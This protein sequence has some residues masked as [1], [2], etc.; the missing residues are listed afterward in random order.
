MRFCDEIVEKKA[1][2]DIEY[3]MDSL[4]WPTP[5]FKIVLSQYMKGN[6]IV[7]YLNYV[8]VRNKLVTKTM[9]LPVV[10]S[11]IS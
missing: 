3:K 9:P 1:S 5:F 8:N 6:E 4:I 11:Y 10:I 7:L 2:L